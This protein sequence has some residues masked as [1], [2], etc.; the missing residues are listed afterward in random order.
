MTTIPCFASVA[1]AKAEIA[2]GKFRWSLIFWLVASSV[3]TALVYTVLTAWWTAFVWAAVA[4]VCV[5]LIVLTNKR[6][7]GKGRAKQ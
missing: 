6:T 4:A 5:T 2:K 3:T 1:A 7:V